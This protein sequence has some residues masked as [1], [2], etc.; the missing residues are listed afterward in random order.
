MAAQEQALACNE[1]DELEYIKLKRTVNVE[2][3]ERWMK[4]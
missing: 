4:A 1:F 2:C 3:V